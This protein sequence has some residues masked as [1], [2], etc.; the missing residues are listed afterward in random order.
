MFILVKIV[1]AIYFISKVKVSPIISKTIPTLELLAIFLA[2]K[3]LKLILAGLDCIKSIYV[4]SDSQ[5]AL[6]W[7]LNEKVKTK[8]IFASNRVKDISILLKKILESR[9]LSF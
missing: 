7:V 9:G 5:V 3:C 1:R 2:L 4:A 6:G 8:N